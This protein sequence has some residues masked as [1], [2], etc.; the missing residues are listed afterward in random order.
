LAEHRLIILMG[1]HVP[2]LLVNDARALRV[3]THL[4]GGAA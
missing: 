1:G 4:A 3:W 2:P